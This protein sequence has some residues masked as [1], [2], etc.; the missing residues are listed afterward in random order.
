MAQSTYRPRSRSFPGR[1]APTNR[2][3]HA[4]PLW[5]P[6]VA[7]FSPAIDVL[8]GMREA[9]LDYAELTSL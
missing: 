2:P 9:P 4:P 1:S 3:I 6:A 7:A 5:M 8:A